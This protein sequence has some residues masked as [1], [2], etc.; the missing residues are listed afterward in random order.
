[1]AEERAV[2]VAAAAE[3]AGAG[4]GAGAP[5]RARHACRRDSWPAPRPRRPRLTTLAPRSPV[6]RS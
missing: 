3:A 5:A 2:E 4:A 6:S 1:M